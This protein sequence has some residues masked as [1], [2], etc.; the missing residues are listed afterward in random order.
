MRAADAAAIA[1]VRD[2][3]EARFGLIHDALGPVGSSRLFWQQ[4]NINVALLMRLCHVVDGRRLPVVDMICPVCGHRTRHANWAKWNRT[5]G[6][7]RSGYR[8]IG[9]ASELNSDIVIFVAK[10]IGDW[11]DP[12]PGME[13]SGHD[14]REIFKRAGAQ[15]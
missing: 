10:L 1:T 8:V 15:F 3:L 11:D 9:L 14:I 7:Q 6:R 4:Y 2:V 13:L 12:S 5:T